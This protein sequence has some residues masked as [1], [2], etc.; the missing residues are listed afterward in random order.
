MSVTSISDTSE[1]ELLQQLLAGNLSAWRV[2][3]QHYD[4]YIYAG[5]DSVLRKYPRHNTRVEREDIRSTFLLGLLTRDKQKLRVFQFERGVRF[6][7]WLGLLAKHAARDHLR[8]ARIRAEYMRALTAPE[9]VDEEAVDPLAGLLDKEAVARVLIEI[10]R[11]SCKDKQLLELLFV[12]AR[13]P[14]HVARVMNIAVDTVYTK[15][16]KLRLRLQ[17]AL[18]AEV[19]PEPMAA[20]TELK[21]PRKVACPPDPSMPTTLQRAVAS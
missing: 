17:H 14:E 2:F 21:R 3:T 19:A 4:R 1:V 9:L 10:E 5:I 13:T 7:S 16:H 8:A 20:V 11:L 15:K 18:A 6:S 12:Q